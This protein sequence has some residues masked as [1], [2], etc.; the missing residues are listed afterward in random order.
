MSSHP[1]P[2]IILEGTHLTLKTDIAFA[3]SEHP[4]IIGPRTH[5][6]HCPLI[7]AEWG[8]FPN[9]YPGRSLINFEP[10]EEARALETYDTWV[11]LF[12]LLPFYYWI[13]DRFHLSTRSYQLTHM[14][15]DYPFI[16]LEERLAAL[17]FRVVLCTRT[18][19]SF[20]QA[21][22]ERLIHS[23]D[24]S[25]YVDLQA[26]V[27]EQELMRRLARESRLSTLELDISDN[28]VV[29]AA[30]HIV[31]WLENTGGLWADHYVSGHQEQTSRLW[32]EIN[33]QRQQTAAAVKSDMQ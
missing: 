6:Y 1:C 2:K 30:D 31:A 14:G 22:A 24:P 21:R 5:R 13:V 8:A 10:H 26:F 23:E 15:K 4:R 29:R 25:Q 17:D 19:A 18:P 7:S 11:R 3:L 9:S 33:R 16:Q 20:A 27:Q 28:D 12:E 32:S